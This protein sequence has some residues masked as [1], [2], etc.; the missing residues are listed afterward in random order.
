MGHFAC[1]FVVKP[2]CMYIHVC[3]SLLYFPELLGIS[4]E[5]CAEVE[6]LVEALSL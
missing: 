4:I 2:F 3:V 1:V 6:W 5:A